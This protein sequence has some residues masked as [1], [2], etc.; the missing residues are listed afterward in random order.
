MNSKLAILCSLVLAS[1]TALAAGE[2]GEATGATEQ[3]GMGQQQ[4]QQQQQQAPQ[5]S[6]VDVDQDGLITE[7]EA[8]EAGA[9]QIAA[10]FSQADQNDDGFVNQSEYNQLL[11]EQ[12]LQE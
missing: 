10:N 3:G 1:G 8:A 2:Y 7:Q 9:E 12:A 11:G 5:F 6:E 4:Q